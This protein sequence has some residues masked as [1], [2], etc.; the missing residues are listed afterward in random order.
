MSHE[1]RTPLAGLLGLVDL[2]RRTASDPAQR[3]YLE[4][5]MQSGRALQRTIAHVLDLTQL[6]DGG[7]TLADEAFDLAE[8]VA[9][10]LRG[11]MPLARSKGLLLR[12]DW[13]GEPTWVRGDELRVRQIVG[14][15]VDNAVRF[16]EQGYVELRASL[17]AH[18]DR[19][20]WRLFTLRVVD[21]GP[22]LSPQRL[23]Q[24]FEPFVQGDDSLTRSHDGAGLGLPIAREIAH[25]MGGSISAESTPGVGSTFTITLPMAAA[26]DP[27]PPP[28]SAPGLAWLLYR[29]REGGEWLQRRL[30]R[31]GWSA[32]L[33]TDFG[34]LIS[35]AIHTP[36]VEHPALLILAE[37]GA[38]PQTD[39]AALRAALPAVDMRLLVRPEWNEPALEQDARQLDL[40]IDVMPLSPR[41]IRLMTQRP[42]V[43]PVSSPSPA[44]GRGGK[45]VL[46]VEDNATNRMIAEAFLDSLGLPWRSVGDGAQA[47]AACA[48]DPPRLVLMDLQM[49]VMDGLSATRELCARQA[50][51]E[52][53]A[54]PIVALTAHAMVGD[55]QACRGAGMSGYLT[56]PLMLEALQ[57]E[58]ARWIPGL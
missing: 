9:E 21:S 45:H 29:Q 10:V 36:A 30:A 52:L 39:L 49:P 47:L 35:R 18:P 50:R 3:R 19:A 57:E 40:R 31:V 26:A 53:P 8:S 15:L 22:G 28:A 44:P 20:A 32:E 4:V 24:V 1:L 42:A 55:A 37:P 48:E 5:A 43:A 2:A 56:K 38:D 33:F 34:A 12:Y 16:T 23:A 27:D 14:N 41:D 6:R 7:K 54:F 51:G 58:L 46:V 11:A 17:V 25:R 13:E